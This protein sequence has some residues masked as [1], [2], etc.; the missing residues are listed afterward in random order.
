V[1]RF[2]IGINFFFLK[3]Q[4]WNPISLSISIY[5]W[6]WNW[7]WYFWKERLKWNRVITEG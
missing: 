7:N 6:N 4:T 3:N 1:N 5:L 2:R